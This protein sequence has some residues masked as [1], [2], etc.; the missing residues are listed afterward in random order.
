MQQ[1]SAVDT[2]F[3]PTNLATA[4]FTIS[5]A[6]WDAPRRRLFYQDLDERVRALPG[7]KDAALS[8]SLPIEGSGWGSVFI[9]GDRP[10][11]PTGQL[12]SAAFSPVTPGYFS[13]LGLRVLA[14]RVLGP[15]DGGERYTVVVNETVAKR[16]WPDGNAVGQRLKQGF[17]DSPTPWREIVGVVSDIKLNGVAQET[18]LQVYTPL[19][20]DTGRTINVIARTSIDP[21]AVLLSLGNLVGEMN[22]DIPVYNATTFETLLSEST[23]RQRVT[24]AILTIFAV[25]ALLLAAIGLFG[26]VSHGVTERTPEI[27][28]RLALGATSAGIVR[29]FVRGGIVTAVV[30]I[31]IGGL[32]AYWLTRFLE[33]LL[34]G[35]EP[36]DRIAFVAGAGMLFLVA[37]IACYVPASRAARV[38]PTVAL[39][40]EQ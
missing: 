1:L 2:G 6:D 15:G 39:R 8:M 16:F 3:D 40:G 12:P 34:F 13:T 9:V 22:G 35:V 31:V 37:L 5:A 18:P 26:I 33:E 23:A 28:V 27:G 38:S 32:G 30:G 20:Q 21:K 24:A 7:V 25:V 14:G 4:R 10:A 17:V 29:L 11:P 19:S 36:L